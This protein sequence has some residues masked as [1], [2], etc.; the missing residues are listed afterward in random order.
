M[1]TVFADG[2][3]REILQGWI[4]MK[5]ELADTCYRG[6]A[7]CNVAG[8]W[9]RAPA[10][11]TGPVFV[12]GDDVDEAGEEITVYAMAKV[13]GFEGA[14]RGMDVALA[15]DGGYAAGAGQVVG[16]FLS[17]QQAYIGPRNIPETVAT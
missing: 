3:P 16:I 15:G 13:G 5:V 17:D 7:I 8:D 2:M 4:P 6:D 12:A 1:A 9:V 11:H 14:G 10:D